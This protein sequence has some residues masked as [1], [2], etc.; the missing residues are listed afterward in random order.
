[1]V[2]HIDPAMLEA[3]IGHT[4]VFLAT[5][6][7][8]A[9]W[10]GEPDPERGAAL[11]LARGPRLVVVKLGAGGCLI[12]GAKQAELVGGFAVPVRNTAGAGDSFSAACIYSHLRGLPAR[13]LGRLCN[14]VGALAVTKLG[15]GT[16]LPEREEIVR[17]LAE[18]DVDIPL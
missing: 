15:A 9:G 13:Q 16:R 5:I 3:V 7:E 11:V 18:H 2:Q 17:F 1:V 4:T 10:L 8:L 6:E 12:V 14:A